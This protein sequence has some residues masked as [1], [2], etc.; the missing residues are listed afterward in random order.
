MASV[1]DIV[2]E[3]NLEISNRQPNK[4]TDN[5]K[6]AHEVITQHDHIHTVAVEIINSGESIASDDEFV[7]DLPPGNLPLN[8]NVLTN[9][10]HLLML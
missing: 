10:Q 4:N 3:K 9:Q 6:G 5:N 1:V 2:L 7:P 8:S